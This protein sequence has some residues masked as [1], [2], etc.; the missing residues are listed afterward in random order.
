MSVLAVRLRLNEILKVR[1]SLAHGFAMPGYAWTQ[2]ASGDTRLTPAELAWTR[3]F[4]NH[5]VASTDRG[6]KSHLK[7]VYAVTPAW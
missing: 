7:A 5:L 3:A 6:I 2:T 4:F 1:H